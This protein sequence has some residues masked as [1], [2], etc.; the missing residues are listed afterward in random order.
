MSPE[1]NDPLAPFRGMMNG[2]LIGLLMWGLVLGA[3]FLLRGCKL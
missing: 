2:V 1:N 3:I